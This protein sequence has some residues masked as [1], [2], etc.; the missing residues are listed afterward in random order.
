MGRFRDRLLAGAVP[1]GASTGT[2]RWAGLG[3]IAARCDNPRAKPDALE[4]GV[5]FRA[6]GKGYSRRVAKADDRHV[7]V[8]A[9]SRDGKG[10]SMLTRWGSKWP[11][12]FF[13]IDPKG[14]QALLLSRVRAER[15][16]DVTILDPFGVCAAWHG[17]EGL[18]LEGS[19]NVL[20]EIDAFDPIACDDIR[21][22]ATVLIQDEK[23]DQWWPVQARN[24]VMGLLA[25]GI[26]NRDTYLDHTVSIPDILD[27][28]SM[29]ADK[30]AVWVDECMV[31]FG[32]QERLGDMVREGGQAYA[33]AANSGNTD[34]CGIIRNTIRK[35]LGVFGSD[36]MRAVCRSSELR[37]GMLKR[38]PASVFLVLPVDLIQSHSAWL[39]INVHSFIMQLARSKGRPDFQVMGMLDECYNLGTL[40]VLKMAVSLMAGEGLKLVT[41]WQDIAQMKER[42]PDSWET[43]FQNAGTTV[44]LGIED[45]STCE[46]ISR[47]CGQTLERRTFKAVRWFGRNSFNLTAKLAQLN[48]RLSPPARQTVP[49][50]REEELRRLTSSYQGGA[51]V[52]LRGCHWIRVWRENYDQVLVEGRDYD[53]HPAFGAPKTSMW[54]RVKAIVWPPLD[55]IEEEDAPALL[56]YDE[57]EDD[58]DELAEWQEMIED[59][60]PVEERAA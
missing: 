42:Y 23:N 45:N 31:Q 38:D 48:M 44:V 10:R 32:L 24:F 40:D 46:Y 2:A 51:L 29:P 22:L 5:S 4:F 21:A 35:N 33:D 18:G 43:F 56:T 8:L 26:Y 13:G 6:D 36:P 52:K 30:L 14:E 25:L 28:A 7:N 17:G 58:A 60:R 55:E 27:I 3:E 15:G 59:I 34:G 12:S 57:P 47:W 41:V 39:R 19:Y 37:M 1:N 20:D 53:R 9:A 50:I 16:Q 54:Q 11:G 49:L